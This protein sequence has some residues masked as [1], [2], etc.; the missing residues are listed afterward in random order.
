M[1]RAVRSLFDQHALC[2]GK[3]RIC[4]GGADGRIKVWEWGTGEL[5][6]EVVVGEGGGVRGF[7]VTDRHIVAA[8]G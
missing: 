8:G 4:D 7:R 2:R 6:E 3:R 5:V 1:C